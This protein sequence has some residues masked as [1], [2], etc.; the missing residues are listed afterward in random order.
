MQPKRRMVNSKRCVRTLPSA[1]E[2]TH[3]TVTIREGWCG[4]HKEDVE[5]IHLFMET[6]AKLALKL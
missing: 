3:S 2:H 4:L 6:L 5:K 1:T